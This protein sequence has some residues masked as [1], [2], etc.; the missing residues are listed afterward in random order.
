LDYSGEGSR[1][2]QK[3][4]FASL[5]LLP[6]V[7]LLSM[8][9]A[10]RHR[11]QLRAKSGA[12]GLFSLWFPLATT[13]AA[14]LFIFLVVPKLFSASLATIRLFQPDSGLL[15]IAAAVLGVLWAMFRLGLALTGNAKPA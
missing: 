11:V 2:W 12:F 5:G 14:A 1:F 13:I 9:W 4:M 3:V 6:I 8:V 15:L 10:W 7:Y